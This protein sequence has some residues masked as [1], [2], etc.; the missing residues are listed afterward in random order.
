MSWKK[1]KFFLW[2]CII[3]RNNLIRSKEGWQSIFSETTNIP[4][5][6]VV[7]G[8][9]G[10]GHTWKRLFVDTMTHRHKISKENKIA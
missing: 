3:F 6:N 10:E 8:E 4:G 2:K 5:D 7:G 1:K 9:G